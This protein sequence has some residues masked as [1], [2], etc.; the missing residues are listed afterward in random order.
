MKQ[1][2]LTLLFLSGIQFSVSAQKPITMTSTAEECIAFIEKMANTRPPDA[3]KS[4]SFSFDGTA[5]TGISEDKD[6]YRHTFK[7]QYID[8]IKFTEFKASNPKDELITVS[9]SFDTTLPTYYEFWTKKRGISSRSCFYHEFFTLNLPISQQTKIPE[10]KIAS[11]RLAQLAKSK[12]STLL[13]VTVPPDALKPLPSESE[14]EDFIL[15]KMSAYKRSTFNEDFRLD[16]DGFKVNTVFYTHNGQPTEEM[17]L[18]YTDLKGI[19][20]VGNKIIFTGKTT[21]KN[22]TTYKSVTSSDFIYG[23]RE[24]MPQSEKDKLL[25]ALKHYVWMK[26]VDLV[27][28][29]LFGD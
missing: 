17:L 16:Y 25:K 20:V 28:D 13:Q 1:L 7:T 5:F 27:K 3:D 4:Y 18:E 2:L 10:L 6:G 21:I 29:D 11:N 12:S 24:D 26:G 19:N 22:L 15:A 9:F 8:W 14:T 23:L